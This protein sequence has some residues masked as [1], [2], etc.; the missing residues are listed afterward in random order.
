MYIY[1]YAFL[2]AQN[3]SKTI[4]PAIKSDYFWELGLG[5]RENK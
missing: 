4:Y 3:V 1:T 2:H 5:L